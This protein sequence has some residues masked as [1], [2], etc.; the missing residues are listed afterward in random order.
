M[1]DERDLAAECGQDW[2][3]SGVPRLMSPTPSYFVVARHFHLLTAELVSAT[4]AARGPTITTQPCRRCFL[5]HWRH[6]QAMR[7]CW[8]LR[9]CRRTL[10]STLLLGGPPYILVVR[11]L[12]LGIWDY[13]KRI[14]MDILVH[15]EIQNTK[16]DSK[17]VLSVKDGMY[18]I[19][20]EL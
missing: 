4:K 11:L 6:R 20:K 2:F 19:F 16:N 15:T 10:S 18:P 9:L 17:H 7:H 8:T 12:G 14:G 1:E 13:G 5:R 3:L